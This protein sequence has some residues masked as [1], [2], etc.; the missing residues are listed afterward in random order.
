MSTTLA[1]LQ[2]RFLEAMLEEA[3]FTPEVSPADALDVY[4][5]SVAANL[6]SALASAYPVT[7]RLVGEAFFA[8]A[9][10]RHLRAVP[11]TSGDLHQLGSGFASFLEAYE[12]ARTLPWLGDVARL[13]WA[14]HASHFAADAPPFDFPAL[15]LVPPESH[16]DIRFMLA[17]AVRLVRSEWPVLAV[18]EANQPGRDGTPDRDAGPDFIVVD[19]DGFAPR[20]RR[21]DPDTW[22]FLEALSRGETLAEAG[23]A[24]GE[25]MEERLAG[26]LSEGIAAGLVAS[27]AA[28]DPAA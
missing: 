19:R 22:R 17:P 9:A 2:R 23:L 3:P 14:V 25:A 21:L 28:P 8:E 6:R 11:S 20:A 7:Q 16:G 5:A 27:F 13:E 15:A 26:A 24:F 18:W 1:A 12:P 10:R 4:R